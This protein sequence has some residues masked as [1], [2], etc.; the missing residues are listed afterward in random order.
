MEMLIIPPRG[1]NITRRC[2]NSNGIMD[3]SF[4][5]LLAAVWSFFQALVLQHQVTPRP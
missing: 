4:L 1:V 5:L 2:K 3:M